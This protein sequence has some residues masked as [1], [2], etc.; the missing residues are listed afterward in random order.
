VG[1]LQGRTARLC[2]LLAIQPQCELSDLALESRPPEQEA[3]IVRWRRCN[4]LA[5]AEVKGLS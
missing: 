1:S 3:S 5:Q 4:K 2:A